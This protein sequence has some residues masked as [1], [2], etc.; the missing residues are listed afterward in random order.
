MNIRF[1]LVLVVAVVAAFFA[2]R[3]LQRS[4]PSL[5]PDASAA[6]QALRDAV[7]GPDTDA[8][9][10]AGDDS[11]RR[12]IEARADEVPVTGRGTVVKLLSDDRE[13]NPHQR[14]LVRVT[15][16]GTVLIAHNIAL[17]PRV[18]PLAVGDELEFAGDYA[19]N[20]KGGVVHW[21]HHDPQGR[22]RTGWVRR[23]APR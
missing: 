9:A 14:I 3:G 7:A 5:G 16:G 18:A 13:G 15:G 22:H 11:L 23:V 2:G 12:A 4:A 6:V 8:G 19:W 10:Y 21:T 17:S 20:D 1:L